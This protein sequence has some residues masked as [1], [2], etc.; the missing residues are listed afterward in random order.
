MVGGN[1]I[2]HPSCRATVKINGII[3][4]WECWNKATTKSR[5]LIERA[6]EEYGRGLL[7]REDLDSWLANI[8]FDDPEIWSSREEG[9]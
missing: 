9:A 1:C 4:C 8:C 5:K 2:C 6:T 3:L 7:T